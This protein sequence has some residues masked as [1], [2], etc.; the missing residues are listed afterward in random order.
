MVVMAPVPIDRRRP[1]DLGQPASDLGALASS[2]LGYRS[3]VRHLDVEGR[4]HRPQGP[5][6]VTHLCDQFR[7]M[8]AQF[9]DRQ[10]SRALALLLPAIDQVIDASLGSHGLPRRYRRGLPAATETIIDPPFPIP[11]L[12][13]LPFLAPALKSRGD[14]PESRLRND[15]FLDDG[16]RSRY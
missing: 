2:V 15:A 8:C 5:D 14:S 9:L 11:N 13:E 1:R 7:A 12:S 10:R 6:P 4:I 3:Q 16:A